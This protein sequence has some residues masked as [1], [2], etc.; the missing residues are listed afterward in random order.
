LGPLS[1]FTKQKRPACWT[2]LLGLSSRGS[3]LA[4]AHHVAGIR[5]QGQSDGAGA[6]S[7]PASAIVKA[8]VTDDAAA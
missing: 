8:A 5:R 1:Q 6:N 2:V 3:E 7:V 4:N